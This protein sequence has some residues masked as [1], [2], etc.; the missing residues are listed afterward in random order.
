MSIGA[1]VAAKL[2]AFH[3]DE[4]TLTDELCDMLCIWTSTPPPATTS[5]LPKVL[6]TKF[7]FTVRKTTPAEE[8][9][10]GADLEI[11]LVTPLGTKRAL[12]QAKVL[13]AIKMQLRCNS[14][15]GWRKLRTQLRDMEK[16][17]PTMSFL[18]AYLPGHLL[19]A[20]T[21]GFGTWEQGFLRGVTGRRSSH[22]GVTVIP[23]ER[24]ITSLG[25]WRRNGKPMHAGGG[26]FALPVMS[27]STLIL[28]MLLC[29]RGSWSPSDQGLERTASDHRRTPRRTL[30]IGIEDISERDWEL[31]QNE[32]GVLLHT[33]GDDPDG[34]PQN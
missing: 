10:I 21:Y 32:A 8:A 1:H 2:Q 20:A 6:T 4:R 23:T 28:E 22:Y 13:D 15:S 14:Q 17:L 7:R 26:R 12:F 18:I 31:L 3:T 29:R 24:M 25:R 11:V 19:N 5:G 34:N 27:F 16:H 9:R 33:D 30:A